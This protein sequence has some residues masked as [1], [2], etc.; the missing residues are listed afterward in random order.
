MKQIL[1]LLL[2]TTVAQ[3]AITERY[4]NVA[5]SGSGDGSSEANAMSQATFLD[6]M[7]TGGSVNAAAGDRFN[8]DTDTYTLGAATTWVN[9][10][11]ASSPVI[12]RGYSSAITDGYQGRTSNVK[13]LVATNMPTIAAGGNLITVSGNFIMLESLQFTGSRNGPVITSSGND[14]VVS[15]CT[16]AGAATGTAGRCLTG[17]GRVHIHDSDFTLTNGGNAGT[18]AVELQG[19]NSRFIHNQILSSTARGLLI[20]GGAGHVVLGN[21][22]CKN[23]TIGLEV[24]STSVTST[25]IGNTFAGNGSDGIKLV[26]GATLLSVIMNNITTDNAGDGLDV[27]ATTTPVFAAY[28]RTRDNTTGGVANGG[29]W[30][31]ATNYSQVTTDND[32]TLKTSA[33]QSPALEAGINYKT[34][35]GAFQSDQSAVAGGGGEHSSTFVQ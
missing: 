12:I 2:T 7:E 8:V 28:I 5:G 27:S 20:S 34:S 9:P 13:G 35:I 4:V 30:I 3:A 31:T 32:F 6:Y 21:R 24:D 16:V 15:R 22:I 33:T 18:V 11:T 29:D 26:S 10:G 25:I 23:T 1:F 14:V 19:A 17:T